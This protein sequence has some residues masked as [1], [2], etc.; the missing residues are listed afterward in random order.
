MPK[1]KA[2]AK[3]HR[4]AIPD[5]EVDTP[6]SH[7]ESTGSDHESESEISFHPSRKQATNLERQQMFYAIY[8]GTQN[9]LDS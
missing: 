7:E 6:S 5:Q 9:G 2:L 8:R 1:V 4:S 3:A